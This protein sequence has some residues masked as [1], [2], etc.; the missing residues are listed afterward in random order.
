MGQRLGLRGVDVC[1]RVKDVPTEP[2]IGA[3]R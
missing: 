1:V 3:A 2:I